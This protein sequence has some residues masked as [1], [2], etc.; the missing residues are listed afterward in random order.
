MSPT[1]HSAELMKSFRALA[2]AGKTVLHLDPNE[3]YGSSQAS[4]TL[5]E[6]V[7]YR[8]SLSGDHVHPEALPEQL[9][10]MPPAMLYPMLLE[11][12]I[13]RKAI[14]LAARK[15]GLQNDPA[16]KQNLQRADDS[17]LQ[18]ALLARDIGP[19]LTDAAIKARY[20]AP[21]KEIFG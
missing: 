15:Q 14:V 21:L 7:N 3:Y 9:Q 8:A 6:L 1:E 2:K 11:Q 10:N 4:L 12:L 20:E 16:V 18:N 13:D 19:T 5:D 17:V